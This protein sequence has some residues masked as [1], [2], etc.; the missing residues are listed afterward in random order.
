MWLVRESYLPGQWYLRTEDAMRPYRGED[1][2]VDD[3]IRFPDEVTAQL[4][5]DMLNA[6][7][8]TQ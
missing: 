7:A 4:Y 1:G 8:E 2:N 6:Q 5:A 3:I